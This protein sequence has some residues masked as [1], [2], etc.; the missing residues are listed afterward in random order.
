MQHTD[1]K[2]LS[3]EEIAD[4]SRI[5]NIK[6]GSQLKQRYFT[7]ATHVDQVVAFATTTLQNSDASFFYPVEA[8]MAHKEQ[9]ISPREAQLFLIDYIDQ[10]F[11]DFFHED[12]G[13][14]IPIDWCTYRCEDLDLQI[15]GQILNQKAQIQADE[16]LA[17]E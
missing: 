2:L 4:L 9:N 15:R 13:V 10:Y 7:I 17:D 3:T 11:T 6:Y 8:R 12:E 1:D 16:I 5:M 14:L